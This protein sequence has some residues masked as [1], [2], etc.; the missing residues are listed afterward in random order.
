MHDY[1]NEYTASLRDGHGHACLAVLTLRQTGVEITGRYGFALREGSVPAGWPFPTADAAVEGRILEGRTYPFGVATDDALGKLQEANSPLGMEAE[2]RIGNRRYFALM[3]NQANLCFAVTE[4]DSIL[5]I[6][7]PAYGDFQTFALSIRDQLQTEVRL[8]L[9]EDWPEA[10]PFSIA[11]KTAIE[12]RRSQIV[13]HAKQQPRRPPGLIDFTGCYLTTSENSSTSESIS[14]TLELT[15]NGTQLTGRYLAPR[16][17]TSD[18]QS[19]SLPSEDF[20]FTGEVFV[21]RPGWDFP[22]EV[23]MRE[24]LNAETNLDFPGGPLEA[25]LDW[26][27]APCFLLRCRDGTVV[28]ATTD[29]IFDLSTTWRIKR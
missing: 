16:E 25:R 19:W 12:T 26:P 4:S 29:R 1:T 27:G 23:A 3:L 7:L 24:W 28:S 5:E 8:R 11:L 10:A 14:A 22:D 21:D 18:G 13:E 20:A 2:I 17:E 6:S 15:Q 9:L